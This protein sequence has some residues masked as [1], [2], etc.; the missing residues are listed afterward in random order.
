[1]VKFRNMVDLV[2]DEKLK[3]ES[4]IGIQLYKKEVEHIGA[5]CLR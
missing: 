1:M 5:V 4:K 2:I 3:W